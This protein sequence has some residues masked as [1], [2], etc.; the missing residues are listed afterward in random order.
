MNHGSIQLPLTLRMVEVLEPGQ[1]VEGPANVVYSTSPT[2]APGSDGYDYFLKGPEA[3]TLVAE[4]TSYL[5]A[6]FLG[7]PVPEFGIASIDGAPF[8]ASRAVMLRNVSTF[9]ER[10]WVANPS[11]LVETVVFDIWTANTDRNMGNFV[12]EW[13]GDGQREVRVC[14]IDFEK[15]A[16][17]CERTPLVIVPTIDQDRFWP[18]DTLGNALAGRPLPVLFCDRIAAV[19]EDSIRR[20]LDLVTAHVDIPWADSCVRVL[21]NRAQSIRR[22]AQEV[23]R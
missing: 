7:L 15:S 20:C 10:S 8:F 1:K 19:T 2:V 13:A 22:L 12:G 16:C 4:A 18:R 17:L 3:E 11:V 9:I 21:K 23:W 14:A 6:A 5:L